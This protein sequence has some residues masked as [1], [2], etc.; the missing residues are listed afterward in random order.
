MINL[1]NLLKRVK[2]YPLPLKIFLKRINQPKLKK[3]QQAKGKWNIFGR[4]LLLAITKQIYVKRIFAYPLVPEPP[5]F[6]HPDGSL[7]DSPKSKV[8][9]YMK[10]LVQSDSSPNVET[11]IADGMLLIRSIGRCRTNRLFV[12]TVLKIVLKQTVHCTDICFDIYKSPSLQD[13]KRKGVMTNPSVFHWI[14]TK[15]VK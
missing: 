14:T 13:S 15:D 4:L 12:Q 8:F 2:F 7:P 6:C 11:V 5:C 9:Q 3:I 1:K 10:G